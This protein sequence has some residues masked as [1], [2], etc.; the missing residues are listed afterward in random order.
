M[1]HTAAPI[2]IVSGPSGAGKSSVS[3]LVA[4][5]FER[6]AVVDAD[7]FLAFIATGWI[8]PNLPEAAGQNAIVGWSLV[9]AAIEFA[10]GGYTTMIDGH[11]FPP[12]VE[13]IANAAGRRGVPV[14]YAVLHADRATCWAR[15]S[16]RSPGRWPLESESF[17]A[18]HARFA[19]LDLPARHAIDATASLDQVASR[20]HAAMA[21]GTLTAVPGQA[22]DPAEP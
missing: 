6:S 18:L 20:L 9:A 8:E 2:L 10:G 16:E 7:A 5:A 19:A 1:G 22:T 14:H 21:A 11:L 15:V 12:A 17:D 4:A 3:R 13:Q